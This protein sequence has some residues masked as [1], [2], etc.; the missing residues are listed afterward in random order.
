MAN[1][2]LIDFS[3]LSNEMLLELKDKLKLLQSGNSE[4]QELGQR[5][6]QLIEDLKSEGKVQRK[7]GTYY[8]S[9][10]HYTAD[11]YAKLTAGKRSIIA[12]E[13]F[14]VLEASIDKFISLF[15]GRPE[16]SFVL[17]Y[18]DGEGQYRRTELT[19]SEMIESHIYSSKKKNQIS[20]NKEK[21]KILEAKSTFILNEHF[22]KYSQQ[23][24]SKKIRIRLGRQ[25]N[26]GHVA[27][28]F[29]RHWQSKHKENLQQTL[30]KDWNENEITRQLIESFGS[31][32]WWAS[33]DV[34]NKQV[35]FLDQNEAVRTASFRSLEELGNYIVWLTT[36][37]FS[38][39]ELPLIAQDIYKGF[40][41]KELEINENTKKTIKSLIEKTL[42][43][44][45]FFVN[46]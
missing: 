8:S 20:L 11:E 43:K 31:T 27:E 10:F 2:K 38:D 28:A 45:Q 41:D 36:H 17:Y 26:L 25:Y 34:G 22:D 12:I 16:T 3:Q 5:I 13:K 40:L 21:K 32:P 46:I 35:K 6:K 19:H 14:A 30:P 15:M 42:A 4:L 33:G 39:E 7:R 37:E 1:Q 29:E 18:T 23:A 44:G 24:V 9:R